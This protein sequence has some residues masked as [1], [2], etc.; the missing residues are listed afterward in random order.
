MTLVQKDFKATVG[1]P[2]VGCYDVF[3]TDQMVEVS[4]GFV[5]VE[6]GIAVQEV[7]DDQVE[8]GRKADKGWIQYRMGDWG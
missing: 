3:A 1:V 6:E 8:L 5:E 7:E 2:A 4:V